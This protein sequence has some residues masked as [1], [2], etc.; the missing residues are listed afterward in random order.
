MAKSLGFSALS[1]SQDNKPI[2]EEPASTVVEKV[3]HLP[4]KV[5]RGNV[6]GGQQIYAKD[7]DLVIIGAVSAGAEVIADGSVHVYGALRGRA[8][9]GA[10]GD[11]A[12]MIFCHKLEAELISINGN[13]WISDSLQGPH[14]GQAAS[15]QANDNALE[16]TSLN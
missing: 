14:W 4:A 2:A 15:V 8:V 10:Q 3:I 11:Q 1:Y 12:A 13:Y 9:A 5:I 16:I 6:R 7:R